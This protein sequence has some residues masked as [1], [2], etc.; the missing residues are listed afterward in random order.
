MRMVIVTAPKEVA[1]K[2]GAA[3]VEEKLAACVNIVPA[4][5]SIYIWKGKIEDDEES[6]MFFKTT[7]EQ[8][9]P[10]T[11]RIRALHPY[12][13]PEIVAVAIKE[14]EGHPDYLAWVRA[15]VGRNVVE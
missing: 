5:R 13:V 10:L 4:V 14:E 11:A 6:M 8:M 15:S 9:A 2:I 7:A 1:P 12:E 3:V